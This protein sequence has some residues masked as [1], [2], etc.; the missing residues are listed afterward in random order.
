[1]VATIREQGNSLHAT[2][3][4]KLSRVELLVQFNACMELI[5]AQFQ[6]NLQH[7]AQQIAEITRTTSSS[8]LLLDALTQK[9][10]RGL[11]DEVSEL[12]NELYALKSHVTKM[13]T[14][15]DSRTSQSQQ[16]EP[17]APGH[18][19]AIPVKDPAEEGERARQKAKRKVELVNELQTHVLG[20]MD[21]RVRAKVKEFES[22]VQSRLDKWQVLYRQCVVMQTRSH[23]V[24]QEHHSTLTTSIDTQ[25]KALQQQLHSELAANTRDVNDRMQQVKHEVTTAASA[26]V[27]AKAAACQTRQIDLLKVIECEQTECKQAIESVQESCRKS[28]HGLEDQVHTLA[29]DTRTKR[30]QT[31]ETV[32]SKVKDVEKHTAS[33]CSALGSELQKRLETCSSTLTAQSDALRAAVEHKV[34]VCE[35]SIAKLGETAAT[36]SASAEIAK[37]SAKEAISRA[38]KMSSDDPK[39]NAAVSSASSNADNDTRAYL[40]AMDAM[41]QKMDLQLQLQTQVQQQAQAAQI[42]P[43]YPRYWAPSSHHQFVAAPGL[44]APISANYPAAPALSQPPTAYA[45]GGGHHRAASMPDTANSG[46]STVGGQS[47]SSAASANKPVDAPPPSL[48]PGITTDQPAKPFSATA[49]LADQEDAKTAASVRSLV[50]DTLGDALSTRSGDAVKSTSGQPAPSV[51]KDASPPPATATPDAI[52]EDPAVK[53]QETIAATAKGALAEAEMAKLR[54]E[55]LRKQEMEMRQQQQQ[56]A[57]TSQPQQQGIRSGPSPI[58][59]ATSLPSSTAVPPHALPPHLARA[60]SSSA[61]LSSSPSEPARANDTSS[62]NAPLSRPRSNSITGGVTPSE[63]TAGLT[64]PPV[65]P[66]PSMM[67]PQQQQKPPSAAPPVPSSSMGKPPPPSPLI[68]RPTAAVPSLEAKATPSGS[69]SLS[70]PPLPV[71]NPLQSTGK[72]QVASAP[73]PPPQAPGRPAAPSINSVVTESKPAQP[74]SSAPLSPSPAASTPFLSSSASHVLCSR[75]RLPVRSDQRTEHERS[76]CPKR[77]EECATC[78]SNVLWNDADAHKRQC[79]ARGSSSSLGTQ[80]RSMDSNE[81]PRSASGAGTGTGTTTTTPSSST[82]KTCRHCNADVPGSDLFEHEL[83]CDK[84]LKQCPHCLRR[85]KLADLQEHIK[86][87]DRRLVPCPN[88]CGGKFLQRGIS[89]HLAA[90]CPNKNAACCAWWPHGAVLQASDQVHPVLPAVP[91]RFHGEEAADGFVNC[92]SAK[93]RLAMRSASALSESTSSN[94]NGNASHTSGVSEQDDEDQLTLVQVVAEWNVESVCLWLH[95]DVG[96]P[97][98][99]PRFQ[100][101]RCDGEMLLDLTESDLIND[102]GVKNRIHCERILNA[103]EAIKTGDEFSDEE[104]EKEV[105]NDE[106]DDEEEDDTD[107]TA[108]AASQRHARSSMGEGAYNLLS[109]LQVWGIRFATAMTVNACHVCVFCSA[110]SSST[111]FIAQKLAAVART[112]WTVDFSVVVKCDGT[113]CS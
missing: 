73:P 27:D 108:V 104:E 48:K 90:R 42:P 101:R 36:L 33:A 75:C 81:S 71:P 41:L 111:R 87:W 8:N 58:N 51:A 88:N 3:Q 10:N 62:S 94:H 46:A 68:P 60:E 112:R 103:I 25:L 64:R 66:S 74:L 63:Q 7:Q 22:S 110:I 72:P 102:F 89:K 55:T 38:T 43:M 84:M 86:D 100:Q 1:M 57:S 6:A 21:E 24:C 106:D 85:Q 53:I 18:A 69:G 70:G 16:Q 39:S 61:L 91:R 40:T 54:V 95:E 79:A 82:M 78:D 28:R 13:T 4:E 26:L 44:P 93:L 14:M 113:D 45:G 35:G 77:T 29:Q 52:V 47:K 96:V 105:D 92:E 76:Q 99:V 56:S 83:R 98:V 20:V 12:R 34:S 23:T 30:N 50:A 109:H 59:A 5:K 107:V 11:T 19:P 49:A 17:V 32:D 2:S 67:P 15:F 65:P 80:L 37:E 9:V 97:E 31:I